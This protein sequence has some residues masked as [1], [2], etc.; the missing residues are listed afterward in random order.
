MNDET[1]WIK[2]DGSEC[3]IPWA[4]GGEYRFVWKN[5]GESLLT[6]MWPAN[7]TAFRWENVEE[8]CLTDGWIPVLN[9]KC[10]QAA[11]WDNWEWRSAEGD[12]TRGAFRVYADSCWHP[13]VAVRPIK[14]NIDETPKKKDPT[15]DEHCITL[16]DGSCVGGTLA[17]K[18]PCMHDD[19]YRKALKK[20]VTV[21]SP[22]RLKEEQD[23]NKF[24]AHPAINAE[25]DWF[26]TQMTSFEAKRKA[27]RET[28]TRK[29]VVPPIGM[30][31]MMRIAGKAMED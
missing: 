27:I 16:P 11:D 31:A 9:D 12:I 24:L 30:A 5:D 4:K 10:P 7:D 21:I 3:P 28:R 23:I 19:I 17:G 6:G 22:G 1:N 14:Q 18:L 26:E 8:F 20:S 2:H 29:N 13:A 15:P 25:A